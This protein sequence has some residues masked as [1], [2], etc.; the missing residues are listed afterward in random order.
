MYDSETEIEAILDLLIARKLDALRDYLDSHRS[1]NVNYLNLP[2]ETGTSPL[3]AAI[4]LGFVGAIQLL[5]ERGADVNW[6]SEDVTYTPIHRAVQANRL[7][8]ARMLLVGWSRS[9]VLLAWVF[10]HVTEL[11]LTT[12]RTCRAFCSRQKALKNPLEMVV[13]GAIA[14]K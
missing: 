14:P 8:V 2:D 3:L 10:R 5:L 12:R 4:D 11:N 6:I 9:G 1:Q 13:F 7:D